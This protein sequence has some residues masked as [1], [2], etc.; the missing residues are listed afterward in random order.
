MHLNL[1]SARGV[2]Q[3]NKNPTYF[4]LVVPVVFDMLNKYYGFPQK[5]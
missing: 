2:K 5:S 4:K 1:R 3:T